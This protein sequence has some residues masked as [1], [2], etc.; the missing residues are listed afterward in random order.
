MIKIRCAVA[1][2]RGR[3]RFVK[4]N[5]SK[6]RV[7]LDEEDLVRYKLCE[8]DADT[9]LS[10]Y[11]RTLFHI[12]DLAERQVSFVPKN[13]KL[14]M[15]FY[16]NES[17]GAELFVTRL[18]I[19]TESKQNLI[20]KSKGLSTMSRSQR[21]YFFDNNRNLLAFL[22]SLREKNKES[23]PSSL[24]FSEDGSFM[25]TLESVLTESGGEDYPEI[26]EFSTSLSDETFLYLRE[27]S[28]TLLEKNALQRLTELLPML[29]EPSGNCDE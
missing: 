19:L 14:L 15:Q 9:D 27:H 16:P 6:L 11:K 17:G 4:L 24:Y 5:E 20:S 13:D 12:V 8:V 25:M 21:A 26:T 18:K 1:V 3:M 29:K 7:Y 2:G 22:T 28:I 23:A 10:R